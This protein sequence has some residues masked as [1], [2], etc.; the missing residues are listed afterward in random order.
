[1]TNGL[2]LDY[3]S[4]Q[5]ELMN[6]N[7]EMYLDDINS[8][9][10]LSKLQYKFQ[11]AIDSTDSVSAQKQ[12]NKLMNEQLDDLKSRDKL[13][14]YDVERAEKLL[15]IELKRIA[16]QEAQNNKTTMRLRRDS[17]GNYTY[18]YVADEEAVSQAEQ[19]L[20]QAEN[21]LYN[22]DKEQYLQNQQEYIAIYQEMNDKIK[23]ILLD[24]TLS[25]EEREKKLLLLKEE[26]GEMIN[27]LTEQNAQIRVN[28][29]ESAL[30]SLTAIY[31]N[32]QEQLQQILNNYD[33]VMAELVPTWNSGLQSMIDKSQD[34]L[35]PAYEELFTYAQEAMDKMKEQLDAIQE[36]SGINFDTIKEGTDT[37]IPDIEELIEDNSTLIS[38][39]DEELE[40]VQD[41]VEE[42]N[43]LAAAYQKAK[44]EAIAAAEAAYQAKQENAED[45]NKGVIGGLITAAG[46][47]GGAGLGFAIGS[48][49][50]TTVAPGVGTVVGGA[51]GSLLGWIGSKIAGYDTGGYTGE[52]N[53]D[54]GRLALLHQKELVLNNEDTK[55]ILD[56]V[57]LVRDLQ[58]QTTAYQT[59]L[60]NPSIISP[61]NINN[62]SLTELK[63]EVT[64]TATFPNVNSRTEIEEA[65]IGLSSQ[66]SQ[67][68]LDRN[69]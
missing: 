18:Q 26:Y 63:Q 27:N 28:L 56:A 50:G 67:H 40:R 35:M 57:Q 54:E 5:W 17:N 66:A 22:F 62:S 31:Q 41:L 51:L 8:A 36:S 29:E 48:A 14:Q 2:G 46:A 12:L 43:N 59:S 34:E 38:Q 10:E 33:T 61:R 20:N 39:M 37:I 9:Y 25:E 65:F 45:A 1:M 55:N 44:E 7:A 52:W 32:N 42:V 15:D 47:A 21:D 23:E 16:L 49:I 6:E 69:R 53:N 58:G 68:I 30:M 24:T 11:D 60:T 3:I 19:E 13:T 64:I 4:E